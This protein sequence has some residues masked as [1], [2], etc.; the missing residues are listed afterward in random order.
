L[1]FNGTGVSKDESQAMA[2]FQ[3]AADQRDGLA[4]KTLA[5][6]LCSAGRSGEAIAV[7]SKVCTDSPSDSDAWLTLAAWQAWFG[8]RSDFEATCSS[9][10]KQAQAKDQGTPMMRAAKAACLLPSFDPALLAEALNLAK[11]GV[12]LK[13]DSAWLPWYQLSLGLAE[14]RSGQYADAEQTLADSLQ[15]IGKHQDI[16]E[17]PLFF[18]ALSLFQLDRIEEARKLFS[19]AEKQMPPFPQDQT[20]PILDGSLASHDVI[21]CWLACK[22]ARSVLNKPGARP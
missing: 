13:K 11:H 19:E 5:N 16:L 21:I 22:E 4:M 2:L 18:R 8:N 17:T 1:Y 7:L 14:Y 6:C 3:K 20:K 12:E 9:F 15:T 10:V